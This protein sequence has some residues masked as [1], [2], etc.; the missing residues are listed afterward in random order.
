MQPLIIEFI[1][2]PGAGKTTIAQ[3]MLAELNKAGYQCFSLSTL[4]NPESVEKN[5]G[6]V[7]SKV[8]TFS[9]FLFSC[10]KDFRMCRDAFLYAWHVR[11]RRFENFK[12]FVVL[13]V[14]MNDLRTLLKENY[15]LIVLDQGILQNI[16][17]IAATGD[18]PKNGKYLRQLLNSVLSQVPEFVVHID[19]DVDLAVERIH[20][21][22]TMRSRFDRLS[23][24]QAGILLTEYKR[25]FAQIIHAADYFQDTGFL[26]VNGS[27]PVEYSVS[28]IVP[29]LE[30][31]WQS[32]GV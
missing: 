27:Q 19:V 5:K 26:Y 15:D 22:P 23:P 29:V 2:L 18:P 21:R 1:G 30:R 31:E 14:R 10:L 16:W 28:R 6:G 8:G 32:S 9:Y 17:S 7:L 13:L 25:I 24:R 3:H 12:R 11:P 4:E 20:Q